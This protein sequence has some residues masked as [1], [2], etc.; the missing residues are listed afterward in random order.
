M[1]GLHEKYKDKKLKL[2]ENERLCLLFPHYYEW[3][4]Q[5]YFKFSLKRCWFSVPL[6]AT[7]KDLSFMKLFETIKF[8]YYPQYFPLTLKQRI[9]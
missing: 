2:L 9:D 7:R 8:F 1:L 6:H 3:I 5:T 4:F